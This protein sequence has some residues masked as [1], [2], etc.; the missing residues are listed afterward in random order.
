MTLSDIR[1]FFF[2]WD[3]LH[4]KLKSRY[5]MELQEKKSTK[6]LKHTGNMFRKNLQLKDVC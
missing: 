4:A 5:G 1:F 2:N 3:S 6:R